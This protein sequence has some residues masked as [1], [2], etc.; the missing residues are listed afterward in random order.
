[1]K[2]QQLAHPAWRAL[3]QSVAGNADGALEQLVGDTLPDVV[4]TFGL[5][6]DVAEAGARALHRIH[7]PLPAG[8]R[9]ALVEYV[10][11]S[12]DAVPGRALAAR[13][14]G[15]YV[16]GNDAAAH[17]LHAA[18]AAAGR[19]EHLACLRELLAIAAGLVRS[20]TDGPSAI[21]A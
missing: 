11:G 4:A 12:L 14:L 19:A 6:R 16:N 13:L 10:P 15:A 9:F 7:G 1:V 5:C 18:A 21:A 17:E 3:V 2:Q 8:T 20:A